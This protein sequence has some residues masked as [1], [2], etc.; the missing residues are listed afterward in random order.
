[1]KKI[2]V[3]YIIFC[4]LI[5]FNCSPVM[6]SSSGLGGETIL[7]NS[8]HGIDA[9]SALL[10]S[11]KLVDNAEA[12]ML[13]EATSDTLMYAWNADERMYP[14]SLVKIMTALIAAESGKISDVVTV[15]EAAVSAIPYDAVSAD[16]GAGE[17]LSMED[18]LHCL[19]LGSANDAAVAIAEHISGSQS[20]FVQL[21]NA[22]AQEI[23]CT[24][25]QFTNAHGLHDDGQF[26]TARDTARIL[27]A[28]INNE[29]FRTVF[30]SI[31]HTVPATNMS[32]ERALVSGNSMMDSSSKLYYDPRVIGGRT[33]VTNDGQRCLASVAEN[34]GMQLICVVMGSETVYQEDGYSAITVGGYKETT[35]LLDAGLDGYKAVQILF[36]NQSI[37]QFAVPDGDSD[38]IMGP[39]ISVSAVLPDAATFND[40][41]MRYTDEIV[42]APVAA[43]RRVSSVEIWYGNM[44]VA[45]AELFALNSVKPK[46][47]VIMSDN[48]QGS[49]GAWTTVIWIFVC[50]LL[51]LFLIFLLPRVVQRLRLTAA[52]KRSKNYMRSR[53]RSR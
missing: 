34:N 9:A 46:A 7:A 17:Q 32:S 30:T 18:L 8:C 24:G 4:L 52:R 16:L 49:G 53:R 3:Y 43:G 2:G 1:M 26:T 6:A 38:V 31:K 13:Y 27:H 11:Q 23:G 15:S 33:G 45:Q 44:C 40:L 25:T 28:A 21:M 48:S 10:G 20:A 19:L 41:S 42:Q 35:A 14:A 36:A 29:V 12:V 37:R 39:Q 22:R 5:C 47:S 50:V 51:V